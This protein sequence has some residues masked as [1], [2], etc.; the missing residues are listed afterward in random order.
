MNATATDNPKGARKRRGGGRKG[1]LAAIVLATALVTVGV[2]A[3][4]VNIFQHKQEAQDTNFAVVQLDD[5]ARAC[6]REIDAGRDPVRA[7]LTLEVGDDDQ[8][9]LTLHTRWDPAPA[10][11][12]K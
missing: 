9:E 7:E 6:A 10:R 12:F 3:L 1:L 5:P 8:P 4:L 11:A 2:V